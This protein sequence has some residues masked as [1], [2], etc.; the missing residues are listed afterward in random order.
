M[1]LV[2][3][4]ETWPNQ[5]SSYQT[6]F[7]ELA[8]STVEQVRT[9]SRF[10]VFET[11]THTESTERIR[12]EATTGAA[13][14]GNILP[15]LGT[16]HPDDPAAFAN[17]Y[18]ITK[19]AESSYHG[20]IEVVYSTQPDPTQLPAR[21]SYGRGAL[22][23]AF[24]GAK[25]YV[26]PSG[27]EDLPGSSAAYPGL[28]AGDPYPITASNY[29]PFIPGPVDTVNFRIL[30]VTKNLSLGAWHT[31]F[32]AEESYR[33]AINLTAW[34]V[35]GRTFAAGKVYM[36][37]LPSAEEVFDGTTVPQ[38]YMKTTWVFWIDELRGWSLKLLDAGFYELLVPDAPVSGDREIILPTGRPTQPVRLDG[39]GQQLGAGGVTVYLEYRVRQR[40]EFADL[41]ISPLPALVP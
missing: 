23:R 4:D 20:Q 9:H 30:T 32:L 13:P 31:Y 39:H 35:R 41:P 15:L 17:A 7:I 26:L 22:Q 37:D 28:A 5:R 3:L 27:A 24:E 11:D 21:V 18:N 14:W 38:K 8:D 36:P 12:I 1:P 19:N 40:A 25:A 34:A 33:Q 16:V 2:F 6:Q 10:Y 29:R